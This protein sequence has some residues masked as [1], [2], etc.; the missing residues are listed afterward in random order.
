MATMRQFLGE[1]LR[2]RRLAAGFTLREAM[3]RHGLTAPLILYIGT[4]ELTQPASQRIF[5]VTNRPDELLDYV[6]D[7]LTVRR[8][9]RE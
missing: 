1:V 6:I 2:A 7:G 4:L 5:A 8:G 9:G 3:H